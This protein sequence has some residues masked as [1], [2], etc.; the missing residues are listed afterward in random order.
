[1]AIPSLRQRRFALQPIYEEASV[2]QVAEQQAEFSNHLSDVIAMDAPYDNIRVGLIQGYE[3]LDRMRS[4][5]GL[6]DEVRPLN[7][8]YLLHESCSSNRCRL[9]KSRLSLDGRATFTTTGGF[10]PGGARPMDGPA[11]RNPRMGGVLD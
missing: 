8:A 9:S 5:P 2:K 11:V 3:V 7:S 1:M 6:R 10:C 4:T